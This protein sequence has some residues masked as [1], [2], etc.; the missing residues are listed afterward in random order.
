MEEAQARKDDSAGARRSRGEPGG[1]RRSQE[2]PG[3]A[4]GSQGEPGGARRSQEEPMSSSER[5]GAQIVKAPC[6]SKGVP[7][8]ADRSLEHD[9]RNPSKGP[10]FA[11]ASETARQAV[12]HSLSEAGI[13]CKDLRDSCCVH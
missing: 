9:A 7:F 5:F 6:H 1:A 11:Q 12:A 2:E 3:E 10:E 13:F 4:R 8:T